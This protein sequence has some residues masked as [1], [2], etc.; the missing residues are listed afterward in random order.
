MPS[1]TDDTTNAIP[2]TPVAKDAFEVWLDSAPARDRE[3]LKA[4]GFAAEP[5]KFAFLPGIDGRPA[6]V[7]VGADLTKDPLWAL[8][9]LPETLPDGRYNSTRISTRHVQRVS[10][11]A[12]RSALMLSRATRNQSAASRNLSGRSTPI[13]PRFNV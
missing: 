4:T 12:G 2:L 13:A 10:R 7:V 5:G 1:L 6:K 9:G 3:W 8:A 11:S